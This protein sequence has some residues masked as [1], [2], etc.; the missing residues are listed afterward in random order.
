[1]Q[2]NYD[3]C[4]LDALIEVCISYLTYVL[5]ILFIYLLA[6]CCLC[7]C[8]L[9]LLTFSFVVVDLVVACSLFLIDFIVVFLVVLY[10]LLFCRLSVL[11][12]LCCHCLFEPYY[13]FSIITSYLFL[14]SFNLITYCISYSSCCHLHLYDLVLV[15][16]YIIYNI[17]ILYIIY[18]YIIYNMCKIFLFIFIAFHPGHITSLYRVLN[19][20]ALNN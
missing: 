11:N 13:S 17:F 19:Y 20:G 7:I 18:L 1:M 9:I 16:S 10:I 6:L 3:L 14:F 4:D 5:H 12:C 2:I 8:L 15:L